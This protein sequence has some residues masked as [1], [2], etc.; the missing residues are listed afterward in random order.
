MFEQDRNNQSSLFPAFILF[1]SPSPFPSW[2]F[3]QAAQFRE[4]LETDFHLLFG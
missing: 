4:H 1:P 3:P 2:Q